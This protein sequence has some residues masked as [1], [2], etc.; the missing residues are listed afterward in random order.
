MKLKGYDYDIQGN[1]IDPDA[2]EKKSDET[3][4]EK[5]VFKF[6]WDTKPHRSFISGD[7]VQ[8]IPTTFAHV[9]PKAQN[10]YPRFK[11]LAINIVFLTPDEHHLWDNQRYKI[12][13]DP[14][15]RRQWSKMFFLEDHLKW[16]Y[17]KMFS[18]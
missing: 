16:L 11:I 18:D 15:L 14:E 9:L 17:A 3:G 8:E 10:K 4:L 2:V 5:F 1:I 6:L 13:K 7:P 12:E